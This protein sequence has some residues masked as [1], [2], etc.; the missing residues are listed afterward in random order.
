[1]VLCRSKGEAQGDQALGVPQRAARPG[2]RHGRQAFGEDAAAAAAIAA[3]PF[4]HAQL[5][6][7]PILRPRQVRQGAPIVTMDAPRWG[8][9]QRTGC[10]GLRRLHAQGNLRRGVVNLAGLEAQHGRIGSQ[11]GKEGVQG[12]RD[13]SGLLLPGMRS[14]GPRTLRGP[15]VSGLSLMGMKIYTVEAHR[16]P[17]YA[18]VVYH[19]KRPRAQII[20]KVT[21]NPS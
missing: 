21:A 18:R 12:C 20:L 7:H 4:A 19:Q 3:K 16:M 6:A 14:L 9:A 2:G 5:E 10:A 1:R 11:A 17:R 15:T 8:S 13:E